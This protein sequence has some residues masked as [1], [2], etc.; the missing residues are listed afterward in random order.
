MTGLC[1]DFCSTQI[2]SWRIQL[3]INR[4]SEARLLLELRVWCS[5]HPLSQTRLI[6]SFTD[7]LLDS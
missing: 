7:C 6:E 5:W 3:S 4:T 2:E 1:L